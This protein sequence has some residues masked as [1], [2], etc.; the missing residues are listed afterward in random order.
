VSA[1]EHIAATIHRESG[2]RFGTSQ[3]GAIETALARMEISAADFAR[4]SGEVLHGREL[5]A[6]LIDEVTVKETSF[7]RDARQLS[8]IPWSS[9]LAGARAAGAE[10][11]RVWSAACATGEEPYSLALLACEAFGTIDPPVS[12]LATDISRSAIERAKAGTYRERAVRDVNDRLRRTYFEDAGDSLAVGPEL[13][14]VVTFAAHNLVRDAVPPPGHG[15][16]DLIL[17]RN[18]LI[19]FDAGM[20]DVVIAAL[21]RALVPGGLLVL[22][23]ADALCASAGRL[24]ELGEAPPPAV[25]PAKAGA[26]STVRP[27]PRA[28]A[29]PAPDRALDPVAHFLRA[30]EELENGDPQA[31][32]RS[33][34]SALYI[35]PRF[36]LAAF[37]LGR[38]HE[39]MGNGASARRAYEQA[40]RSLEHDDELQ[41]QL[42]GQVDPADVAQAARIRLEALDAIG[43][44]R[45]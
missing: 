34:R 18:I 17:C 9:L 32:I 30:L 12:I 44:V 15:P 11:L 25:P 24:R 14:R 21:R 3:Y 5:L 20:V 6:R 45:R 10:R 7:L 31:A 2:V 28:E 23:A 29:A 37:K 33:L 19:Y 40:L 27:R 38:A 1:L 39:A 16:F 22:G 36:G 8:S 13:R 35:E 43:V 4:R 26:T 42:L 41:E